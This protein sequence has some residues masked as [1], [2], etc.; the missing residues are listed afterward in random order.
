MRYLAKKPVAYRVEIPEV[1]VQNPVQSVVDGFT[2]IHKTGGMKQVE[3]VL[4]AVM[5]TVLDHKES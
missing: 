4:L 3:A 2:I 5:D 1:I